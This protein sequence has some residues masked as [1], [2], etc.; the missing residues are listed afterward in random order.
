LVENRLVVEE[1]LGDDQAS[2]R[3][4]LLLSSYKSHKAEDYNDTELEH[5]DATR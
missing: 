5:G 2:L 1:L 3:R 4:S